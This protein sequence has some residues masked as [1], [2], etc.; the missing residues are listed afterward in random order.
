MARET[1]GL[2][3]SRVL[4]SKARMEILKL[5]GH[6]RATVSELS[7]LLGMSKSTVLYHLSKLIEGEF[8]N[9]R[10]NGDRKWVYYELSEKG[11]KVL[12]YRK[13]N[14]TLLLSS[15]LLALAAGI[16]QIE[17]YVTPQP[18][19]KGVHPESYLY[20]GLVFITISLLLFAATL[21]LW[22]KQKL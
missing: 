14:I 18:G 1:F 20:S 17:R 7:R 15:S 19:V 22:W 13:I 21:A 10:E 12:T 6:R 9:R 4:D 3:D 5:L 16:L 11:R 8:I 2:S